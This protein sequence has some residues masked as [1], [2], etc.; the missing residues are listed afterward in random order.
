MGTGEG[1]NPNS[2]G[3]PFFAYKGNKSYIFISYAHRDAASVFSIIN[4]FHD[5]GYHI[6]YDEGIDPGNEWPE[7]IAGALERCGLF[8]VFIS[9]HSV[10]SI[11]VRNEINFALSEN[12]PII[13]IHL[14]E[15]RLTAG[16]K[17]QIG[18][19]QAIMRFRMDDASFLHKCTASFD[20]I[21]IR[22]PSATGGNPSKTPEAHSAAPQTQASTAEEFGAWVGRQKAMGKADPPPIAKENVDPF[23]FSGDYILRYTGTEEAIVLPSHA[24]RIASGAFTRCHELVTVVV[25]PSVEDIVAFSF[26]GCERLKGVVLM[27]VNTRVEANAFS[28]CPLLE[29]QCHKDTVTHKNLMALHRPIRFYEGE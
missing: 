10:D 1:T 11:N 21:G 14:E 29:F 20:A 13:A 19:K 5:L 6:W 17:L 27:G 4:A 18:S 8:V 12:K 2:I 3:I 23:V 25:P 16:L 7:E 28:Q 22:L 26:I 24:T 15:T 9:P